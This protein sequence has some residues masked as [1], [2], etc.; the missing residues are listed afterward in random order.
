MATLPSSETSTACA[1][2]TGESLTGV[3]SMETW[4]GS[5]S[6]PRLSVATNVKL[7]VPLKSAAGV[8][9]SAGAVPV[10]VPCW[11]WSTTR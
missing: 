2:A 11:G 10:R 7:S 3:T 5:E 8:Y 6:A 1:V 4:A 9:V